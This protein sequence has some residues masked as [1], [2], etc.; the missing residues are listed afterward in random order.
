MSPILYD[1]EIAVYNC[2]IMFYLGMLHGCM[3]VCQPWPFIEAM[4]LAFILLRH[5]FSWCCECT[6]NET[7]VSTFAVLSMF[8]SGQ[9]SWT[10]WLIALGMDLARLV[11]GRN[12][13]LSQAVS[14][15]ESINSVHADVKGFNL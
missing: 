14:M 3:Y 8:T 6:T 15:Q 1:T 7:S 5:C 13:P 11:G 12:P 10:S 2:G 9:D 4:D